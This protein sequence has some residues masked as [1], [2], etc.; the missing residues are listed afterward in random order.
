MFVQVTMELNW[1]ISISI[2]GIVAIVG[3]IFI[4][5][6]LSGGSGGKYKGTIRNICI[7]IAML[8]AHSIE[9]QGAF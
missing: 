1:I 5:D 3:I 7:V 2:S 8:T 9:L 4:L 6:I